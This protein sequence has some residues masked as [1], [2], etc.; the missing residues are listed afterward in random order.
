MVSFQIFHIRNVKKRLV[1]DAP[2]FLSAYIKIHEYEVTETAAHN[3]KVKKFVRTE[4]FQSSVEQIYFHC[5]N[6][7]ADGVDNAA[8]KEPQKG[9]F[10]E[11]LP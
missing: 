6:D 10:R 2:A 4:I 1:R 8:D 9:G 7:A 11:N 5:V 3:K